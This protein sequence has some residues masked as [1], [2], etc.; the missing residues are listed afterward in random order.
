M[1]D[2]VFFVPLP[3]LTDHLAVADSRFHVK[4]RKSILPFPPLRAV[5]MGAVFWRTEAQKTEIKP[6]FAKRDLSLFVNDESAYEPKILAERTKEA[7]SGS[8]LSPL[9]AIVI[10]YAATIYHK[11]NPIITPH[12]PFLDPTI[13]R[14]EPTITR[15]VDDSEYYYRMVSTHSIVEAARRW[16]I[17]IEFVPDRF[18]FIAIGVTLARASE[19]SWQRPTSPHD[20]LAT[21]A[22]SEHEQ[23]DSAIRTQ[24]CTV[25]RREPDVWKPTLNLKCHK[26]KTVVILEIDDS[27]QFI[28]IDSEGK[29]GEPIR[30]ILPLQLAE[31][32]TELE[33]RPC[34]ILHDGVAATILP[35]SIGK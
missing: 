11:W 18:A 30:T 12:S 16:R 32:L 13:G 34:V 5:L 7:L 26:L 19:S 10:G 3:F 23:R 6:T 9:M 14:I 31:G 2:L 8:L 22:Q 4:R 27:N 20:I 28:C 25:D 1:K 24:I 33:F 35:W 29:E 21:T 17:Q 15:R